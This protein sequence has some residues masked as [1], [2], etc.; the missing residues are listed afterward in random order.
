MN[1]ADPEIEKQVLATMRK[2]NSEVIEKFSNAGLTGVSASISATGPAIGASAMQ[3][4]VRY[5]KQANEQEL[6]NAMK[7]R[8]AA[9]QTTGQF[10][11][12]TDLLNCAVSM[13]HALDAAIKRDIDAAPQPTTEGEKHDPAK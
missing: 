4:T 9:A 7:K 11:L 13:Q 8:A 1:D 3:R 12:A 2:I 6:I 5:F 10:K